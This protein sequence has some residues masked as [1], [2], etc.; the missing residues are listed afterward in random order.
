MTVIEIDPEIS[1]VAKDHFELVEDD[2]LTIVIDDGL[3]YLL[4]SA[5]ERKIF[6]SILF[7]VDS[8]DSSIGISC[9]PPAFVT[10][11]MLETVKQCLV[12]NG[13]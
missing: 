13:K 4:K 2:R 9:P 11:G 12:A 5:V 8:K 6:K 3:E 1:T 10:R 7:D